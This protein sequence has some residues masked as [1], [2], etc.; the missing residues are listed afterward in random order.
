MLRRGLAELIK[1]EHDL[2]V[3]AEVGTV[4]EAM[5]E[6]PLSQPDLVLLDLG[7]PG[8]G[9]LELIKD[10]RAQYPDLLIL[11]ISMHDES[12]YAPRALRAGADGYIMKEASGETLLQA[13][14]QVLNGQGYVSQTMSTRILGIFSGRNSAASPSSVERLSDR[15]FEVFELIGRGQG[16]HEIAKQL[17]L[18]SKTVDAHRANIKKK[19]GLQS[20]WEMIRYAV[21]WVES[22]QFQPHANPR[23]PNPDCPLPSPVPRGLS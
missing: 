1:H 12:L 19:L 18:S 10:I 22:Q 6:I 3:C 7:L 20:S 11:V 17:F 14:R 23:F 21:R 16:S 8:K 2:E 4:A 13:I 9:G 15:E 5:Q